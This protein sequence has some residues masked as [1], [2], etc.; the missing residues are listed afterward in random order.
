MT[1]QLTN[2]RTGEHVWAQR[3]D[4]ESA[5]IIAAQETIANKIYKSVA[6][7]EGWIRKEE[8]RSAWRKVPTKLDEYDYYLRGHA[9]SFVGPA[10]T[11]CVRVAFGKTA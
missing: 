8:E 7:L 10:T 5:D 3:F 11:Q 2:A 9:I 4:E 1:V 6:G